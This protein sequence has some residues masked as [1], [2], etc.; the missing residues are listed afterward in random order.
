MKINETF[1]QDK[2][3]TAGELAVLQGRIEKLEQQITELA[4]APAHDIEN[5]LAMVVFSGDL[6]KALAAF[7]IATGA[8]ALGLKVSI[9]FTFWGI[10]IIKK[11]RRFGGKKTFE[12][13]FT[14]MMPGKSTDLPLSQMNYFGVG[15]KL[16][17]KV[18]NNNNVISLEGLIDVAQELGIRFISCEMSQQLLGISDIELIDEVEQ[19]DVGTFLSDSS[20][21]KATLFI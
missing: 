16:I 9:F 15:A 20:R 14:A 10:N 17:R 8:A 3:Q 4:E 12:K 11:G 1:I 18:M 6:D 5:R 19:G 7:I 21:S 2:N 13:G